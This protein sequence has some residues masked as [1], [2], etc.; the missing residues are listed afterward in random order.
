MEEHPRLFTR[1]L[2]RQQN[3][4]FYTLE[5]YEAA[6]KKRLSKD[7]ETTSEDNFNLTKLLSN[8][9][10]G[11]AKNESDTLKIVHKRFIGSV[12]EL[13]E[14]SLFPD[15][16][17]T[18]YNAIIKQHSLGKTVKEQQDKVHTALQKY[19]GKFHKDKSNALMEDALTIFNIINQ[20]QKKN[21]DTPLEKFKRMLALSMPTFESMN[22][23]TPKNN[24]N[25]RSSSNSTDNKI[26]DWLITSTN[27]FYGKNSLPHISS[28]D[29]LT[30][31]IVHTCRSC[32]NPDELQ[33]KLF[34][35]IGGD[36]FDF[37]IEIMSKAD[38]IKRIDEHALLQSSSSLNNYQSTKPSQQR[39]DFSSLSANQKRKLAQ[40]EEKELQ[41]ALQLS[42][43]EA[44]MNG[45]WLQRLG[46]SEEYLNNERALGL[47]K[48]R[49]F[50]TLFNPGNLQPEGTREYYE[51]RGSLPPGATKTIGQGFEEIFIPAPAK[52][53][54]LTES[55]SSSSST[56]AGG[57]FYD[58]INS[59]YTADELIPIDQLPK[60]AQMAFTGTKQLNYIQSKV[61]PCAFQSQENMLVCAP[62]G[63]G[64]TNIAMLTLL[65]LMK[66]H[67]QHQL[68][69]TNG[70]HSQAIENLASF[71]V[72]DYD[73]SKTKA[74]YI[75]P[76]KALA[77]EVVAK[78]S[79]K[80]SPMGY[81]VK[82]YTGELQ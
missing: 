1:L 47:Q 40:K 65:Q 63:A 77:Q 41:Q 81:I 11:L 58:N 20:D 18:V 19:F 24:S 59:H 16:S 42:Q 38:E 39:P 8:I 25:A 33:M 26:V 72:Q 3:A 12:V 82:E 57:K 62:T 73:F 48:N 54:L 37:L 71:N 43:Q 34:E 75:A 29:Q 31:E 30:K 78:F 80:L 4:F 49:N 23:P 15:A 2:H 32:S 17:Y 14:D 22:F 9:P 36:D 50:D 56:T 7:G 68:A 44:S 67:I 27:N 45:D 55:S 52:K 74:I 69:V 51:K 13:L 70:E 46:F 35:M 61:Y 53:K 5:E 21:Y 10:N 76:L 28:S 64:K 60:W 79:E 6:R 66:S